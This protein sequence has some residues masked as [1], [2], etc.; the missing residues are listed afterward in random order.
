M[1]FV[2][3]KVAMKMPSQSVLFFPSW[4]AHFGREFGHMAQYRWCI[5]L[6]IVVIH[7]LKIYNVPKIPTPQLANVGGEFWVGH[8]ILASMT[9]IASVIAHHNSGDCLPP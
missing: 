9:Q 2:S 5:N 1:Y 8:S 7:C 3:A 6:S 4:D